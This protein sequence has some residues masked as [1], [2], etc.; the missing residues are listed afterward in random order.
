MTASMSKA[1]PSCWRVK[2]KAGFQGSRVE[3]KKAFD[4]KAGVKKSM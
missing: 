3:G 2:L 1:P 4:T